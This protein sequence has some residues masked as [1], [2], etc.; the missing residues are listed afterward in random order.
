MDAPAQLRELLAQD[1]V[2]Y[3][4]GVQ[5]ALSAKMAAQYPVVD[6]LQQS[7][8]GTAATLLGYPDM[9][10]TSLSETVDVVR[11]M[12]RS[13]GDTP[14]VVDGDTG[15]GGIANLRHTIS[16][17]ENTGAAGIFIEDQS[18]PKQCGLMEGKD[19]ISADEM[20][21]KIRAAQASRENED[22]VVMARTDAYGEE[23]LDEAIRRGERLAEAGADAFLLGDPAPLEDIEKIVQ[24]IDIPYY[25][26]G[27]HSDESAFETWHPIE[28]YDQA[29]VSLVSDVGGLLQVAVTAM[30]EYMESMQRD[31]TFEGEPKTLSELS[32]FLGAQEY[33]EFEDRFKQS[34]Q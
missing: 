30:E 4:P 9:N 7:G 18:V 1:S 19:L 13:A 29:G 16:E 2:A 33:G 21:A 23:G 3:L 15:Y 26:L 20:A 22:F 32:E 8:Y 27:V 6:G 14:V 5:D 24:A 17:I 31:G 25:A 11:S 28:K 12:V 34:R 10:F